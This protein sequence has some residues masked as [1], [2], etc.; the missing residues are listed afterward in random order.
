M[1]PDR[2]LAGYEL[3]R[4]LGRG[5]MGTVHLARRNAFGGRE[6]A[7]KVLPPEAVAARAPR[8]RFLAE[9]RA[10][11]RLRHANI[12]SILEVIE[13][14]ECHA[15]AMEWIDGASLAE[16]IRLRCAPCRTERDVPGGR[17]AALSRRRWVRFVARVGV[18]VGRAL[19]EV[20]RARLLHR[21]V[22]PSNVLVR[23][24]G[25]ALLSDFGLVLG[26]ERVQRTYAGAFRGTLSY[27]PP[28]QARGEAATARSDVYGLGATLYEA[29][30]LRRPFEGGSAQELARAVREGG[31]TPL[32][33]VKRRTPRDLEAI[34]ARAMQVDP[35]QRYATADELAD[36]LALWLAARPVRARPPG[37]LGRAG[38]LLARV[39]RA[40]TFRG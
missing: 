36:D 20:H 24:D 21:D 2:E 27:A 25:T 35:E 3:L 15:Y 13:S 17:L 34:V 22:K 31:A 4:E 10:L 30:A 39:L 29:L 14:E 7:L 16:L 19:G 28:E 37:L 12:V 32:R 23:A 9:A 1:T 26:A 5:A 6:V 33:R 11:S 8:Q 38:R 18:D 40:V